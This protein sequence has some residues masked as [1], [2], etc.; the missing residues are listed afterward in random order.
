MSPPPPPTSQC[1]ASP[2]GLPHHLG[3]TKSSRHEEVTHDPAARFFSPAVE[4]EK[5][6]PLVLPRPSPAAGSDDTRIVVHST[7][8]PRWGEISSCRFAVDG[9]WRYLQFTLHHWVVLPAHPG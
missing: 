3:G 6:T 5:K 2:F 4:E 1:T 7:G 9:W 8:G